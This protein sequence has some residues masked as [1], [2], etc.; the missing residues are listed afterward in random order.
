MTPGESVALAHPWGDRDVTPLASLSGSELPAEWFAAPFSVTTLGVIE[1]ACGQEGR[2]PRGLKGFLLAESHISLACRTP[3]L[4]E[5]FE[6]SS[7][8][9]YLAVATERTTTFTQYAWLRNPIS[10]ALVVSA[11]NEERASDSLRSYIVESLEAAS[12]DVLLE[13]VDLLTTTNRP[14]ARFSASESAASPLEA[15]KELRNFLHLTWRELEAATGIDENTFYY[16]QRAHAEPRPSTVRKLMS[17]YGIVYA[18]VRSHGE[19]QA[20]AWLA[21]GSPQRMDLLL[22]GESEQLRVELDK[23]L[24]GAPA[25]QPIYHAYRS[26][27]DYDE[28]IAQSTITRRR[29]ALKPIKRRRSRD[30]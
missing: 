29:A 12:S 19:A 8:C 28:P 14:S 2:W 30:R 13:V 1:S 24:S 23:L 16:W 6:P 9:Y 11:S 25:R 4:R 10:R 17:L 5:A 7:S 26:E 18:L 21:G 15:V 22:K 20:V 3:V 27:A